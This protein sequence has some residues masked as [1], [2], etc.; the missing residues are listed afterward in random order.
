MA[1]Y[2]SGIS[3]NDAASNPLFSTLV[4]GLI[5]GFLAVVLSIGHGSLLFSS[6]LREYLP[7]SIGLALFTTIIAAVAGALTSSTRGVVAIVQ[8][9]PIVALTVVTNAVILALPADVAE[10]TRLA[11]VMAAIAVTTAITGLVAVVIG[12]FRL[13]SLIRFAPY[14]V[15]GGFLAGTGWLIMTGGVSLVT[16]APVTFALLEQWPSPALAAR[17]TLTAAFVA[18]LFA[19]QARSRNALLLPAIILAALVVFDIGVALTG[20]TTDDL[21]NQGWLIRLPES[22]ELW[23]PVGLADVG[24][25]DWRA[26]LAGIVGLPAVVLLTVAALLMN[27]TGIELESERD[28]DL[29]QEMR[30]VGIMNLLAAPGIGLPGY[31]S[32]SLTLLASRLGAANRWVGVIVALV[33]VAA[34]FFGGVVLDVVP[35]VILGGALA[36]IGGSLMVEWLFRSYSRLGHREYWVIVFIFAIIVLV[37]FAIGILAG[38]VAAIA[39]F[40]FEYSRLDIVRHEIAGSG[41]QSSVETT[42]RR[43]DVLQEHG[44]AILIMRLQ[45]FLFFGTAERLRR[46]IEQRILAA[47]NQRIRYLVADCGRVTGLDSSSVQSFLRLQQIAA[48]E[49]FT[50]VVTGA[51]E[52]M[53]HALSRG[54]VGGPGHPQV[55][56]ETVFDKALNACEDLVLRDLAP[57]ILE[58]GSRQL[59]SLLEEFVRDADA[60]ARIASYFERIAV[61]AG[62]CLI[63]EGAPSDDIFFVESGHAAVEMRVELGPGPLRLATIGPGAIVGE[64]AFYLGEP[65]SASIVAEE[66]MVI[67]NFSRASLARLERE[68]PR[69]AV[70]FHRSI[71]VVLARRLARTNR[72]VRLL[73]D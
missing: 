18:V 25:I 4:A 3:R 45:G 73:A 63:E 24:R 68:M 48:R 52:A 50:L 31:H 60:A 5:C 29:D 28:V 58:A 62:A 19:V 21:R 12:H 37:D 38:L 42:E 64:I 59:S 17:L 2:A 32:V 67:W 49:H 41:Y 14:P 33:T 72:T 54:G 70:N 20:V 56:F 34:L 47:G 22:G 1:A 40:V 69:A 46:R 15:I 26:V 65:R 44:H 43:R 11:T 7:I 53:R 55:R 27:A 71:A 57:E 35:T 66:P 9:I 36:W 30:A 61:P 39:L 51:S 16:D 23:P 13:G 10:T 8:E 6:H